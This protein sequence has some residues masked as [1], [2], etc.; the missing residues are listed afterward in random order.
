M[1]LGYK[2]IEVNSSITDSSGRIVKKK[3]YAIDEDTAPIVEKIFEMYNG[4]YLMADIIKYLNKKNIKT[5]VGGDFNKNS[6]ILKI[7]KHLH[8]QEQKQTIY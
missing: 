8:E 5:S 7:K 3:K 1:L 6:I 4:G 2:L